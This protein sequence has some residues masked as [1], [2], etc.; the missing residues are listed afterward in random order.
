M[1]NLEITIN[2]GGSTVTKAL[3]EVTD[4]QMQRFLDYLDILYPDA[5][6]AQEAFKAWGVGIWRELKRDV[7]RKERDLAKAAAVD[8]VTDIEE[9]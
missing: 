5:P 2:V 7:V 8:G 3:P 6:T 1:A 9:V 4:V